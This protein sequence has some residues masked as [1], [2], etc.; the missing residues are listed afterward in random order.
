VIRENI[1]ERYLGTLFPLH[2]GVYIMTPEERFA[3][4]YTH[5]LL[6]EIVSRLYM[7]QDS[8]STWGATSILIRDLQTRAELRA[9]ESR[10]RFGRPWV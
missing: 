9:H 2:K 6:E 1:L 3:H 10:E 7:Q 5:V 4:H 8:M